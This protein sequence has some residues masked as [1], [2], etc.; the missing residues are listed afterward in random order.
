MNAGCCK[1]MLHPEW[2]SAV[3]PASMFTTAPSEVVL[4]LVE[5]RRKLM[6]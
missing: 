1:I 5:N 3:F 6:E 4:R 2:K